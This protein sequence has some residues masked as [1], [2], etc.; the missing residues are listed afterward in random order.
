MAKKKVVKKTVTTTVEEVVENVGKTQIVCVLDS[1][2]SMSSI[3]G[4]A[5]GG[6]NEFL[7]KQK[8]QDGD[9]TITVALFDSANN[10]QLLYDN[11]DIKNVEPISEKEWY[12]RGMTALYDGI[13]KTINSVSAAHL[14]LD[15]SEKPDKVLV[16]IVTDGYENDSREY[17][18]TTIKSLISQKEK[19]N[20]QFVYLAADQDA[21]GAGTSI[22]ISGGNTMK[23]RNSGA[24]NAV[25]FAALDNATTFYR[26]VSLNDDNYETLTTNVMAFANNGATE[27]G[28]DLSQVNSTFTTSSGNGLTINVDAS[29]TSTKKS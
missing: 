23:Y 22:G 18:Q 28:E 20:W 3:I 21:F 27:V 11:V 26:S 14:K 5:I 15:K 6:F 25:M 19:E 24:G 29:K 16:A 17:S 4:D 13:G 7:K 8:E 12:P 1:S 10:Y 9:A 2:G